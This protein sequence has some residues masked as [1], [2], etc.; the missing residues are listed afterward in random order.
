MREATFPEAGVG[1]VIRFGTSDLLH[2]HTIYG[3]NPRKPL[4]TGAQGRVTGGF[5]QRLYA[6][7]E[8]GDPHVCVNLLTVGLK[9]PGADGKL[10]PIE[11]PDAWWNN[12]P[13]ALS[14]AAL[15]LLKAVKAVHGLREPMA[16]TAG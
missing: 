3:G 15:P 13:F 16:R 12:P 6:G 2:L 14:D 11:R 8:T 10:H 7:I 5:W 1:A 9:E 4:R